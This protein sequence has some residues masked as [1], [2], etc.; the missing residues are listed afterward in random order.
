MTWFCLEF[1]FEVDSIFQM[2]APVDDIH[3]VTELSEQQRVDQAIADLR[4]L[5]L[6][7]KY[8]PSS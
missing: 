3:L 6:T 1:A 7:S 2:A 5:D 8:F 4:L